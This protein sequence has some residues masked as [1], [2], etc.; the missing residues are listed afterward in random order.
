MNLNPIKIVRHFFKTRFRESRANWIL[1]LFGDPENQGIKDGFLRVCI[2]SSLKFN[3]QILFLTVQSFSCTYFAQW[4]SGQRVRLITSRS[5]DRNGVEQ[6]VNFFFFLCFFFLWYL[7]ELKPFIQDVYPRIGFLYIDFFVWF[8]FF[9]IWRCRK[10]HRFLFMCQ[11]SRWRIDKLYDDKLYNKLYDDKF[12]IFLFLFL[13]FL[14]RFICGI[15]TVIYI[16]FPFRSLIIIIVVGLSRMNRCIPLFVLFWFWFYS[17]IS[18]SCSFPAFC[19]WHFW[20]F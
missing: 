15:I 5:S 13:L 9:D 10:T 14:F 17:V 1:I 6:K 8:H 18:C 2:C 7:K 3:I 4:R 12:D 19:E 16:L 11:A 20:Y